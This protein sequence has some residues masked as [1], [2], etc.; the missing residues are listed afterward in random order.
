ML[1]HKAIHDFVYYVECLSKIKLLTDRQTDRQTR[2]H[3][4][5][6]SE[7]CCIDFFGPRLI[8]PDQ[9]GKNKL[10]KDPMCASVAYLEGCH[11]DRQA[12]DTCEFT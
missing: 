1:F 4:P 11:G 12:A 10:K 9:R 5:H 8:S 2:C 6:I 3:L 7:P